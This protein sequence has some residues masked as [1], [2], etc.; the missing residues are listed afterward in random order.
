ME[1]LFNNLDGYYL[2]AFLYIQLNDSIDFQDFENHPDEVK[3]TFM[4]EY[5][6]FLQ[7]VSTTYGYMNFLRFMQEFSYKIRKEKN[8]DD[9]EILQR[10][11]DFFNLYEGDRDISDDIFLINKVEIIEDEIYKEQYPED[12]AS[13][14]RV[15]YNLNKEFQFG[16]ICI[17]ESMAYLLEKRLYNIRKRENEFP[18]N[19]CEE[20]CKR[21]YV[22]FAE[23]EMWIMALCELSLLELNAGVFFIS[24]LRIMKEKRFIPTSIQD[25]E[26]FVDEHF[27]I[28]FR[29]D[30]NVVESLLS[31]VYLK[32]NIDF[33]KIR[34][35]ILTRFELG[36][37]FREISKCFISM[38]LCNNDIRVRYGI[39]N[40]LIREFGCPVLIDI[41]GNR[42][43]GA[44]LGETEVDIG[45]MLAPMAI[46]ELLD[47]NGT[48]IQK[49]CPL[50]IICRNA[51]D[52]T[53]SKECMEDLRK[54]NGL[55]ELCPVRG[56]WRMYRLE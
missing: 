31:E 43:E 28:G 19:V 29:G 32:C 44:Y 8:S 10:N 33:S 52:P 12:D 20:I 16:N 13:L 48:F 27:E 42:I 4:H 6:H 50:N 36:C 51:N 53:Y 23:N 9:K 11:K 7:D 34:K 26:L 46:N 1:K 37:E 25:I 3:G 22:A 40:I 35:W 45:Y 24:A 30:K 21:E 39:W 55:N 56:F 54:V 49:P 5:C 2:P 41:N 38:A 18:Y 14:I 17:A 15:K 47:Y